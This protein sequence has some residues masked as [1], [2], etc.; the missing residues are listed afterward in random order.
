MNIFVV[1][2]RPI[3]HSLMRIKDG[4]SNTI[5]VGEKAYDPERQGPS[6]YWDEPYFIGGSKGTSRD[7]PT[8]LRDPAK[9][10]FRDHWGSSHMSGCMFLFAD[11]TVRQLQFES[12]PVFVHALMTPNGRESVSPP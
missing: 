8:M 9:A 7:S 12:D 1:D 10:L 4:Q 2:N 3:C 5:L 6:W 11:A